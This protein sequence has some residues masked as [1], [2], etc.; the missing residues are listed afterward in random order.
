MTV[1]SVGAY[2]TDE[3]LE[4]DRLPTRGESIEARTAATAPGG[5]AANQAVAA[6][7][8]G[9]PTAFV[10]AVGADAQGHDGIETLRSYGVDVTQ[11]VM[12]PGMPTGRSCV[13]LETSGAQMIITFAGA[14]A[15]LE[16]R[17]V[18]DVIR[19][20]DVSILLLQGEI[21]A[22]V[23]LAAASAVPDGI[24]ILDPSPSGAFKR[25]GF[26]PVDILTPNELEARDL[27]G[28]SEPNARDVAAA[29]G[30]PTVLLTR[31]HLGV[32]IFAEGSSRAVAAPKA[33]TIDTTGAGDAFNGALAAALHARRPLDAAVD[34]AAKAAAWSVTRKY[35]IPSFPSRLDLEAARTP[36]SSGVAND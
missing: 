34:F 12:A 16:T 17:H 20:Y 1:V 29:T 10:G 9:A 15:T 21:P 30:V 31:G 35:C 28:L 5:K 25:V 3:Y 22:E 24:V 6:A 13:L 23:T 14:A 33:E 32:D 8:L 27:T 26:A 7:R 36:T 2:L 4:V 11:V 18:L 19:A